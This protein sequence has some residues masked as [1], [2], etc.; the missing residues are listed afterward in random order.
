MNTDESGMNWSP[1][2]AG[3]PSRRWRRIW[4]FP[5]LALAAACGLPVEESAADTGDADAFEYALHYDIAPDTGRGE[6]RLALDVRQSRHLLREVRFNF[7]PQ[8]LRDFDADGE[9]TVEGNELRWFVPESGGTLRWTADGRQQR[10]NNGYDAWLGDRWGLLRAERLIPRAETRTQRGARSKTSFRFE[11]PGGWS[12]ITQYPER[13][14]RFL[15]DNPERRYDE[16]SGWMVMGRLGVRIDTIAGSRVLVAAPQGSGLRRLD[17]MAFLNWTLPEVRRLVDTLPPRL[18]VVGAGEPMWRGGLSA[19]DSLYL[20]ADRPLVSENGTSTLL[21]EVMHVTLGFRSKPGYD[22]IVEGFAEY[23][24]LELLRR[25]GG[26][27]GSRF[28]RALE[29][30]RDWSKDADAL[31]V[32]PSTGARTARAVIVLAELDREI[33]RASD[34][35]SSLDD[36]TARLLAAPSQRLDLDMLLGAAEE[37]LGEPPESLAAGELPGCPEPHARVAGNAK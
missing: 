31:C 21:H 10:G 36:L 37:L 14:G 32:D 5:A 15:V 4:L 26:L 25:A 24:S 17:I 12:A 20:H 2:R 22:W 34:N 19:S 9:L 16:P 27:S 6:F 35:R 8:R 23:Y 13:D 29:T 18:T 28:A 30:L 11:L 7:D 3:N 1:F 33:R